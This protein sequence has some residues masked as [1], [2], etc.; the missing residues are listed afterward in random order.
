MVSLFNEHTL[1]NVNQEAKTTSIK[2]RNEWSI[3]LQHTVNTLNE[4]SDG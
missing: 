1:S 2:K 4:M 3:D